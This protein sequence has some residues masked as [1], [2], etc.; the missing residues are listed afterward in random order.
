[1]LTGM[2]SKAVGSDPARAAIV[3][4][5][6]R[7][8]YHELQTLAGRCA[9][10]LRWLGIRAGDCVAVALPNCPEFVASLFGCA[11][12]RAVMLPLDPRCTTEE[13]SSL[14]ADARARI[15]IADSLRA[16]LLADRNTAVVDFATLL[17]HSPDPIPL[18][19]FRGP[20]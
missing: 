15:V 1:M 3:Q 13:L 5:G 20:A 8:Q 14:V 11:R 6:R 2:L 17:Q 10:G 12:L 18:G 19:Q 7:I 16:R 9:A 4:G